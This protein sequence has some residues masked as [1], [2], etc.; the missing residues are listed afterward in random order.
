[1]SDHMTLELPM[2]DAAFLKRYAER[3]GLKVDDLIQRWVE[4]LRRRSQQSDIHPEVQA[5]SGIVPGDVDARAEQR[6]HQQKKHGS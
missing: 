5:I 4:Q 3:R 1:M 2:E 6:A